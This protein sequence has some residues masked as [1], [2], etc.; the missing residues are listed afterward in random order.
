M[1]DSVLDAILEFE[2]SF[3]T[4]VTVHDRDFTVVKA[5]Q[6][7][8][9]MLRITPG[10]SVKCF[11]A[12]HGMTCPPAGCPSCQCLV[13]GTAASFE[14]FEPH[15]GRFFRFNALPQIGPDGQ[16]D[17]LIHVARDITE[18]KRMEEQILTS[19]RE[20]ELLVAEIQHRVRN[21]LQVMNGLLELQ[22]LHAADARVAEAMRSCQARLM[23]MGRIHERLYGSRD[24]PDVLMREYVADLALTLIE[25]FGATRRIKARLEVTDEPMGIATAMPC[26]LILNELVTNSLRHAFPDGR[27]GEIGVVLRPLDDG[28]YELLVSDDGVGLPKN[29]DLRKCRSFGLKLVV[30]FGE[31]ELGGTL[32]LRRT[33]GTTIRLRFQKKAEVPR[34]K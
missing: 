17:S 25:S 19:L 3:G 18:R 23:S 31:G 1:N 12:Y 34:S 7:A 24:I 30:A 4:M 8:R 13:T 5:N 33:R 26:G 20:K 32:E 15:L 27:K 28:R 6:M 16:I 11:R 21:N 14:V 22:A 29:F 2:D 9:R 10:E